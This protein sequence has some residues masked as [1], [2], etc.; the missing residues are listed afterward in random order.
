MNHKPANNKSHEYCTPASLSRSNYR[1]GRQSDASK[2]SSQA[3]KCA[4]FNPNPD[5]PK[6]KQQE[7]CKALVSTSSNNWK[8]YGGI[9]E[10]KEQ[11]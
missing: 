5:P 1:H 6:K 3:V 9:R 2:L 4:Y 10:A 7:G 11:K 8:L